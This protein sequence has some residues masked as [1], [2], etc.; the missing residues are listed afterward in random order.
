MTLLRQV[1]LGSFQDDQGEQLGVGIVSRV[2]QVGHS[3][4]GRLG[5]PCS[6]QHAS[7]RTVRIL[8]VFVLVSVS[9]ERQYFSLYAIPA[10]PSYPIE[11]L[12]I[13]REERGGLRAQREGSFSLGEMTLVAGS[14]VVIL[15]DE[16]NDCPLYHWTTGLVYG[17]DQKNGVSSPW[18]G[19]LHQTNGRERWRG[20]WYSSELPL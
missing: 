11:L 3:V 18:P 8:Y 5:L 14:V 12:V 17:R 1:H 4:D 6:L 9:S 20:L 13:C 2:S 19:S 10:I 15:V 7:K 16:I